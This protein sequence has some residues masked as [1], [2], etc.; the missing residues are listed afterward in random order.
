[1]KL[2]AVGL[3]FASHALLRATGPP[4]PSCWLTGLQS[5]DDRGHLAVPGRIKA[6]RVAAF[7]IGVRPSESGGSNTSSFDETYEHLLHLYV[8]NESKPH[9]MT[10]ESAHYYLRW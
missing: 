5:I 3:L 1:M 8:R 7:A 9:A 6:A 2:A 10:R 4:A